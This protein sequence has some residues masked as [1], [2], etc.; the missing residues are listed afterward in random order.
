MA[1]AD[2]LEKIGEGAKTVG[3]VAG[4][5]AEPL[6]KRTAEV[7]SGEAPEIDQ[8]KRARAEK[9][10]DEQLAIKAS[11]LENNLAMG[12]KY[13]T[14]TPDQQQQYV[15][16]I[17]KIYSNP[18][19][20]P[21]LME[22]LRK[23]I[24]PDGTFAQA[25][26]KTL[27]NPT[28]EGGTLH[29]DTLAAM[30]KAKPNYQNFKTPEGKIVTIDENREQP[31]PG[32]TK[33]GNA[34]GIPRSLGFGIGPQQAIIAMQT[35]N[36]Q[37]AKPD[38][39]FYTAA[40][41][42]ALPPTTQLRAYASGG[43]VFYGIA[44]QTQHTVTIGNMVYKM[45]QFGDIDPNAPLGVAR[46]GSTST[47]TAPGGGQVVTATTKPN[48]AGALTG[49]KPVSPTAP[50]SATGAR[51]VNPGALNSIPRTPPAG[52]QPQSIL[53]NIQGMTPHNAQM[54][55][56]AQ[57]AVTALLG[58]YGDPQ[59][60]GTPSMMDYAKLA[61]DPHAQKTL[62]EAFKLLDQQMGEISDPGVL[63]TLGTAAGWANFRAQAESGAQQAAG[64]QMTPQERAYFD[65]AIASMADII[66]S[67]A[68]TGQSAARFSV[69]AIQNEL[70]L[71]GLSGTPDSASYLT[72]MQTI[73]RQ[74]RVGLNGMPD[75]SRALAWLTKREA[76]IAKQKG[77]TG[78]VASALGGK[79]KVSLKAA[80]AL[81]QNKG[82]TEQQVEQDIQA[83]GY[84]VT[85][86]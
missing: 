27:E 45:D 8:D 58:L 3:R 69:K 1:V 65:A 16:E 82:K 26:Q 41:L 40:E 23:A 62:G 83:R 79:G 4:A 54:A 68:A 11:T 77:S 29:A 60:P 6:A 53:P 63:Q 22:K 21:T 42:A 71:I 34:S 20:A 5:V 66:G 14:L 35:T 76:D 25:P 61:D 74:I 59:N 72:K 38:G 86:P 36:Q 18:R 84:E 31:G 49:A 39:T 44:D 7:V 24:H 48:V 30:M 19:H 46:V 64:T 80:M 47:Q 73:G 67:R 9:L 75:N 57:P 43:E 55:Q 17:T 10:E 81:P 28:P 32:W 56:K 70:P 37:F 33:V 50:P 51:P 2:L 15:D 85:R 13:G 52:A 12:Q 78:S